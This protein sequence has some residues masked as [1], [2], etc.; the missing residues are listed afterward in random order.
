MPTIKHALSVY[1][2]AILVQ[3]PPI[4]VFLVKMTCTCSAKAVLTRALQTATMSRKQTK[5]ASHALTTAC[6]VLLWPPAILVQRVTTNWMEDVWVRV[7]KAILSSRIW[8]A[9]IVIPSVLLAQA[10]LIIAQ[11]ALSSTSSMSILVS[12]SALFLTIPT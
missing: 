3:D 7:R 5:S 11:N 1:I 6:T 12:K 2:L 8:S 9:K 10:P 4:S